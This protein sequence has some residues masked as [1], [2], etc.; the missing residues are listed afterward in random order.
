[1]LRLV[2]LGNRSAVPLPLARHDLPVLLDARRRAAAPELL[3]DLLPGA[4]R[5]VLPD[6]FFEP[7]LLVAVP[8]R[9][10]HALRSH[11][12]R[13]LFV[14]WSGRRRHAGD[15]LGCSR[16]QGPASY[17]RCLWQ[18]VGRSPG[19]GAAEHRRRGV[20]AHLFRHGHGLGP[21]II[22]RRVGGVLHRRL[23]FSLDRVRASA[24][25]C[26]EVQRLIA[27]LSTAFRS[28]GP[29]RAL[30]FWQFLVCSRKAACTA[31]AG[32]REATEAVAPMLGCRVILRAFACSF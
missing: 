2:L 23:C 12:L 22:L 6:E 13:R 7:F 19:H 29:R 4:L 21:R 30:G 26:S 8:A 14:C 20:V 15:H 3:G 5:A 32:S 9:S 17:G 25:A 28:L 24:T 27:V 10:C 11:D 18:D 16:W 1:M 31:T